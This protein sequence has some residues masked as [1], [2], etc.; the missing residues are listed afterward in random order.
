M[1]QRIA[2]ITGGSRGLGRSTAQ[3]LADR[4]T[5]SII[6]YKAAA[7]QARSLVAELAAK[8]RTAVALELDVGDSASFAAFADRVR[9]ELARVWQRTSFDVLVN[10][11]G[12]ANYTPFAETSEERFDELFRV[13]LKGPYFLTQRLLPLIADGGTIVNVSTGLTRVSVPGSSAYAIMKGGAEV[14]SR[15]LARELGARKITANTVAP[16]AVATD[17][18]GGHLRNDPKLGAQVA[19]MTALGRTAVADD[20]GG[21]IAALVEPSAA[22]INGQRI[23]ASGGMLV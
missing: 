14:F 19:A 22:W 16:G 2:L 15:Y 18:G 6:T 21:A 3:H 13:H 23:E 4:G 5:D 12:I 17:F 1:T 20:I 9:A 10:N 11:A 7:D 8:G